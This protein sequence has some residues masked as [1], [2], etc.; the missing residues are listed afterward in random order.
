MRSSR[1]LSMIL[2]LQ[3]RGRMTAAEFAERLEVSRRTVLRDVEALSA[4]GVPV[5][6]ER[7]HGGGIVLLPGSRLDLSRLEPREIE[8]LELAG[9]DAA[10]RE[11]LGLGEVH[12]TAARK[13]ATRAVHQPAS[14]S[15]LVIIENSPWL[16]P[17]QEG[18]EP[19]D[20]VLD[21][22]ARTR[23]EIDYRR[24]GQER[25]AR[26]VVDPYGLV[27]KAGRWY[28]VADA[29]GPTRGEP[30]LFALERLSGHRPLAE[31]V[32]HRPGATLA[33][34][35]QQLRTT[36][37]PEVLVTTRLRS[38]WRDFARRVLGS[39]IAAIGEE[40]DGWCAMTVRFADVRGV[41]QLLQFAEHIEVLGPPRA[42]ALI[43]EAAEDL[44]ARH[45]PRPLTPG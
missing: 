26:L 43:R 30:R 35:W 42:R 28:L 9:L 21:L 22:R 20:L 25:P 7:G 14:L 38:T 15:E 13:L 24:S 41:R 27:S 1:L 10:Q 2:L 32:R 44:A 39:R 12:E 16:A 37:A 5:Y 34:T 33:S 36:D 6:T 4:M 19:A 40:E 17:P 18:V 45:A 29:P 31:A 8:A 3:T 11:R 23:W